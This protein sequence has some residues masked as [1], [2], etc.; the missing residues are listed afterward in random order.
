VSGFAKRQ[1]VA[2]V[3]DKVKRPAYRMAPVDG[4]AA[5][6]RVFAR[7]VF[8]SLLVGAGLAV[9]VGIA[10]IALRAFGVGGRATDLR[11]LHEVHPERPWLYG[12]R[13]GAEV[14]AGGVRYGT[15]AE[16]FRDRPHARP[17]PRGTFRVVV[18]G[19]SI[20]FGYGVPVERA[21]PQLIEQALAGSSPPIDVVNLAVSGYNPYTEA[22]LLA[23]VG[24][25][26]EPDLVLVEFCINDLNDPTLHFD[27][28]T[29]TALANLPD[30]AFPP[31]RRAAPRPALSPA[32]GLCERLRTCTVARDLL[33]PRA[34]DGSVVAG[35]LAPHEEP[36]DGE[37]AWLR[38]RYG[39]MAQAAASAGARVAIVVFPWATQMDPRT[40]GHLEERLVGLGRDAGWP[41]IDLLPAFR[42]ATARGEGPLFVDLWHPTPLGHR[43]AADAVLSAL[44]R[45]RLLPPAPSTHER[46]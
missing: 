5:R 6:P 16:G 4:M 45:A 40:S 17:K 3:F 46:P 27:A 24:L 44:R 10:E 43:V 14:V 37:I 2:A 11:G 12:M 42:A 29:F 22:A 34:L 39:E 1:N 15:N 8:G 35:T 31:P 9:G 23:D 28:S 25:S 20:A 36:S 19:D 7:V 21:F 13:P 26:Y 18:L 38:A 30:E 32:D 41:V 33:F